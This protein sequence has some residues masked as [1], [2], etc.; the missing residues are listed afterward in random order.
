MG[1]IYFAAGRYGLGHR[2][3]QWRIFLL[4]VVFKQTRVNLIRK[5]IARDSLV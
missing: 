1:H 4:L 5:H 3:H 2:V